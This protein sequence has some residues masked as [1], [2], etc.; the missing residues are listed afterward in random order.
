MK[1][2]VRLEFPRTVTSRQQLIV[3]AIVQGLPLDLAGRVTVYS[4]ARVV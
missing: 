3:K 1:P 4:I 2:Q